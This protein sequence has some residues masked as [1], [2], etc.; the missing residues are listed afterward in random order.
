MGEV[1]GVRR[2]DEEKTIGERQ[3]R[4]RGVRGEVRGEQKV[5]G[6]VKAVQGQTREQKD[7]KR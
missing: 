6:E 1:A 2:E 7:G 5:G 3:P 4:V